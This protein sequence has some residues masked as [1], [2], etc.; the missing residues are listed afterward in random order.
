MAHDMAKEWRTL[1]AGVLASAALLMLTG[2]ANLGAQT[3]APSKL[4]AAKTGNDEEFARLV[5]EWTTKPEFLSP[6]VDHLPK[7]AGVPSPRD[8]LGYHVGQPKKL[9]YYNDI[10]K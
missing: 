1:A 7:A 3:T 5:R 4:A 6:L 8:V 10:L 2:A 9:T